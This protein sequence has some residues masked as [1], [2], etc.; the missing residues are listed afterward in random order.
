MN[1]NDRFKSMLSALV[2]LHAPTFDHSYCSECNQAWPCKTIASVNSRGEAPFTLP[3]EEDS[4]RSL[5]LVLSEIDNRFDKAGGL[6]TNLV[7]AFHQL[8][9][10]PELLVAGSLAPETVFSVSLR[11]SRR[12]TIL[13]WKLELSSRPVLQV[14][15]SIDSKYGRQFL[16][17]VLTES[18]SAV[19]AGEVL[20]WWR[21]MPQSSSR[22]VLFEL[23]DNEH[24]E[25]DLLSQLCHASAMLSSAPIEESFNDSSDIY[26]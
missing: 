1:N 11:I 9:L 16:S 17:H 21:D 25:I 19:E 20:E 8:A 7:D 4:A 24:E 18:F 22:A 13:L 12:Q 15:A 2:Q 14:N 3:T 26:L 6:G 10:I 23:P 5:G